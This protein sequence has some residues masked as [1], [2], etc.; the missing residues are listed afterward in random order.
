MGDAR[1]FL[2]PS[3]AKGATSSS[4]LQFLS[5]ARISTSCPSTGI[6]KTL[7]KWKSL[8]S[9]SSDHPF[10]HG[11]VANRSLYFATS[12]SRSGF[13]ISVDPSFIGIASASLSIGSSRLGQEP[14]SLS[15]LETQ[16]GVEEED[17]PLGE[18][19]GRE[20]VP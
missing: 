8:E 14:F 10:A 17:S 12:F 3:L 15:S 6:P 13:K 11:G 20:S 7:L 16:K 2:F 18:I 5:R 19:R 4:Q 1:F 9:S